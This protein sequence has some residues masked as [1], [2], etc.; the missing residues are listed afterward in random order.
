[1]KKHASQSDT[2]DVDKWMHEWAEREGKEKGI[3]Y[4]ESYRVMILKNEEDHG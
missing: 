4:S 2:H 3:Q 1:M